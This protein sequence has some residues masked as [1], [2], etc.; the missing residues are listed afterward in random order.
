MGK[1]LPTPRTLAPVPVANNTLV[2]AN[3]TQ[4][5]T[6]L[7]RVAVVR[8][9]LEHEKGLG[10]VTTKLKATQFCALVAKGT[11]GNQAMAA[12]SALGKLPSHSTLQRWRGDYLANGED[13]L[14][15]SHTGRRRLPEGWHLLAQRLYLQPSKPAM[16]TVAR[17][18]RE[19]HNFT[20]S[21][22]QVRDYLRSLPDAQN[23]PSR[24]G[25]KFHAQNVREYKRRS[26]DSLAAGDI[27]MGDGHRMDVYLAHPETGDIWRPELVLWM[28][29]KSRVVVGWDLNDDE[30]TIGTVNSLARTLATHD[31]V[32]AMLYLDNGCGYRAKILSDEANGFYE[33]Y[34]MQ[35]IYAIPGNARAKGQVERFFRIME[36]DLNKMVFAPFYC[37]KDQADEVRSRL[38]NDVKR[39]LKAGEPSPLPTIHQWKA[40]FEY[41]LTKYHARPHPEYAPASRAAI[42]QQLSPSQVMC[43]HVEMVRHYQRRTVRRSTLRL[44]NREYQAPELAPLNGQE[45]SVGYDWWNDAVITVRDALSDRF[46]C[47]A[48]LVKRSD[49]VS[50]SFLEDARHKRTQGQL[51]RLDIKRDEVLARANLAITHEQQLDAI[52]SLTQGRLEALEHALAQ[53]DADDSEI[54]FDDI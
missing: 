20:C 26:A 24:V 27:Y 40:A 38:V 45:V 43:E 29:V 18:L 50:S 28:D 44:L 53:S 16:A 52:E 9:L 25:A 33:R 4:R 37:G 15:P 49:F 13:G 41:W 3:N 34:G 7:R 35:V 11:Y 54:G 6:A 32:P 31:H 36:E 22:K 23:H 10:S 12:L 21:D 39:A 30:G 42:W 17:F 46:I 51:K 2:R 1:A 19:E 47:E 8:S 48:P 5:E 14:L